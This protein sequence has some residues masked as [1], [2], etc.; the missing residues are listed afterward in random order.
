MILH[1]AS[2]MMGGA[3]NYGVQA[4]LP[5]KGALGCFWNYAE[6]TP[7]PGGTPWGAA[8]R[9]PVQ[10]ARGAA[11]PPT[12]TCPG[13]ASPAAPH[14]AADATITRSRS[15]LPAPANFDQ[16]HIT[17]N[18]PCAQTGPGPPIMMRPAT[19]RRIAA[20]GPHFSA[21]MGLCSASRVVQL[22]RLKIR[23]GRTAQ[24]LTSPLSGFY[25]LQ[26]I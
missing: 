4:R 19:E 25:V 9:R 16:T 7:A 22:Q 1:K 11:P 18:Q 15:S 12:P 5:Q 8:R 13:P 17:A 2:L 23:V 20:Q 10:A 21:R 26:G 14:A 24:L 6:D 3:V